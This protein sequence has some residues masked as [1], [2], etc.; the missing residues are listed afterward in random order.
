MNKSK[1]RVF[2]LAV[3]LSSAVFSLLCFSWHFDV[4]LL[5]LPLSLVFTAAVYF[6]GFSRIFGKNDESGLKIFRL[7][8][9][10]HPY[11]LLLSFVIRRA[12]SYGTPFFLDLI[13]VFFWCVSSVFDLY[14][15][16]YIN[17]KRIEKIDS[18]WKQTFEKQKSGST[19]KSVVHEILGWVDALVQ[20]VFM[21]FLINIFF[22]QLYQI[23]SESMVPEFLI[24]D[25]VVVFKTL[26]GPKFPLSQV[27]L[28]CFKDY[29]RG[30]I[31]VFRNPHYSMDRKS[32]VKTFL[33]QLVYMCTLTN[34]NLNVDSQGNPKADPLV[35]RITGVPGEQLMMQDGSLYSRTKENP[36]WQKVEEDST[37]AMW[38][39]NSLKPSLKSKVEDFPLTQ[40]EYDSLL[41]CEEERRNFD[42]FLFEQECRS[43]AKT[44]D[45]YFGLYQKTKSSED[46]KSFFNKNNLFEYAL[47]AQHCY[48]AE[49]LLSS[50]SGSQWFSSFMTDWISSKPQDFNG[51]LYEEANFKLNLMIKR[52]VGKLILTD[53][54]FLLAGKDPEKI[55]GEAEI[56][57][58]MQE[59]V[60]LNTY[61]FLLDRRNMGPF[62]SNDANG[63]AVFIPENCYFMMGDN[64][65]NSLDMRHSYS[66]KLMPLTSF[67]AYSVTYY[68]SLEPQYVNK[69]KILGNASYRFYPFDRRGVPGKSASR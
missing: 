24:K 53:A 32:E 17:P 50:Q 47:F 55:S 68:T 56:I 25:R 35:K 11:V 19:I 22:L 15:L 7:L 33:S 41:E 46:L 63:Q 59:A 12:G 13:T 62:P 29:K 58:L 60:K 67:D 31:V 51:N 4:S 54:E 42:V 27:G 36:V 39:L 64:R 20:A 18:K 30:D 49:K 65:F 16:Y 37:Y 14:I 5:A 44:F 21:V 10:Y 23:P 2:S 1:L 9:Q 43:I 3:S 38:N 66:Q 45:K 40:V 8:L 52:V 28:P 48:Y 26:S 57:D 69:N 34:V 61:V 6:Q